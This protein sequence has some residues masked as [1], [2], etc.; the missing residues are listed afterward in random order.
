MSNP[1]QLTI[2]GAEMELFDDD[3]PLSNSSVKAKLAWDNRDNEYVLVWWQS[4][5]Y[6]ATENGGYSMTASL[7]E[8]IPENIETI[9]V[10]DGK[11]KCVKSFDRDWY[12][13]ESERV[14]VD[15]DDPRFENVAPSLQYAV[16]SEKAI[17]DFHI[18]EV[19]LP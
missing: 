12:D 6:I 10:V 9:W 4:P 13:D 11:H 19:E 2:D 1:P 15:P 5:F 3:D 17:E 18:S 7:V 8:Q 14:V 16:D